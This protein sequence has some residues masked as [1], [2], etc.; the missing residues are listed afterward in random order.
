MFA[1]QSNYLQRCLGFDFAEIFLT[2]Q[3]SYLFIPK[4]AH[5]TKIG[6]GNRWETTNSNPPGLIKRS[7]QSTAAV[8]LC[9]A[10][11][12]PQQTVQKCWAKTI[13]QSQTFIQFHLQGHILST[14]VVS[15]IRETWGCKLKYQN[16][17]CFHF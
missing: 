17:C 8:R 10:F 15:V 9:C 3:F 1:C 2:S 12:Q 6:T 14:I 4:P 7:S 16:S 5:K 11:Y 13:L